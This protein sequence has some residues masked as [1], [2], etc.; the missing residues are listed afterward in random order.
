MMKTKW[1][2]D[3]TNRTGAIYTKKDTKILWSI[4]SSVDYDENHIG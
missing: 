4:E 1:D 2:N 3:M